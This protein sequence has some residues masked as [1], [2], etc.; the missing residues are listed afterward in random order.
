MKSWLIILSLIISTNI[1]GFVPGLLDHARVMV[2]FIEKARLCSLDFDENQGSVKLCTGLTL[3]KND[4]K[5]LREMDLKSCKQ[6]LKQMKYRLFEI[7]L[8]DFPEKVPKKRSR[9]FFLFNKTCPYS[10]P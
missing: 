1:F 2:G 6:F 5:F 8:G 3:K 9:T 10:S 7:N 4:L